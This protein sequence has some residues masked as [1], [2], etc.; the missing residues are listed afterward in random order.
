MR[1]SGSGTLSTSRT[2][3]DDL[4]DGKSYNRV[5]F[6]LEK[7][8]NRFAVPIWSTALLLMLTGA[9]LGRQASSAAS[10]PQV[11]QTNI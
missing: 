11:S 4:D 5:L 10:H 1:N 7:P 3:N 6:P 2:W 9:S 8:M